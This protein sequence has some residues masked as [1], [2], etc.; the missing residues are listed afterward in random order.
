[1]NRFAYSLANLKRA[2]KAAPN[3]RPWVVG[4]HIATGAFI[5]PRNHSRE[6]EATPNLCI[7]CGVPVHDLDAPAEGIAHI[8]A[9]VRAIPK[10]AAHTYTATNLYRVVKDGGYARLYRSQDGTRWLAFDTR[11]LAVMGEPVTLHAL[12]DG[13]ATDNPEDE[14]AAVV[15]GI[16]FRDGDGVSEHLSWNTTP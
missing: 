13:H 5:I 16:R 12:P 8:F 2:V 6:T 1:M 7:A 15:M 11:Y 14:D 3:K 4:D 9:K 10:D